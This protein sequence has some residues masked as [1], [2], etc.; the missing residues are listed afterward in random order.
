MHF[1]FANLKWKSFCFFFNFV[2][3]DLFV[4]FHSLTGSLQI[5]GGGERG[6]DGPLE[7]P[8]EREVPSSG[9]KCRSVGKNFTESIGNL[10]QKRQDAFYGCEKDKKTSWFSDLTT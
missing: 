2:L 9:F 8:S 4:P 10:D 3:L 7:A 1:N 6:V 5:R